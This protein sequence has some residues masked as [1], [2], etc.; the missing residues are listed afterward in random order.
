MAFV[1]NVELVFTI[2][3]HWA[4]IVMSVY[5]S[6]YINSLQFAS[7]L[8]TSPLRHFCRT[9][10]ALVLLA[11]ISHHQLFPVK[12]PYADIVNKTIITFY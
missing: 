8:G 1:A 12:N 3:L 9:F 2:L 5:L 7:V 6:P 4:Y 10:P 11:Q